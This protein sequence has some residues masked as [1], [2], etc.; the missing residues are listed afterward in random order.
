MAASHPLQMTSLPLFNSWAVRRMP[1]STWLFARLTR[2]PL[3][4]R[5][6]QKLAAEGSATTARIAR[7]PASSS[8]ASACSSSVR[9]LCRSLAS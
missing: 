6:A 1:D 4:R 5:T 9:C 3:R 7:P 8:R 2:H